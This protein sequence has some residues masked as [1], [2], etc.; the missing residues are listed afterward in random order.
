[1]HPQNAFKAIQGKPPNPGG[2][3]PLERDGISR[4]QRRIRQCAAPWCALAPA[5]P[6]ARYR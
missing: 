5:R 4:F 6:L 2:L 3:A 1:M